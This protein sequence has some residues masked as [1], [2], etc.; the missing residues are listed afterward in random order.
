MLYTLSQQIRTL[1]HWILDL[2]SRIVNSIINYQMT[3]EIKI[4]LLKDV[5]IFWTSY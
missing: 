2:N 4:I 1:S 3:L 5:D